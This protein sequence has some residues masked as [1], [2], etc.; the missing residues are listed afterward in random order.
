MV[1]K[2]HTLHTLLMKTHFIVLKLPGDKELKFGNGNMRPENFWEKAR[3][4][5]NAGK[6]EIISIR[7]DTG[8]SEE[9]RAHLAGLSGFTTYIIFNA[10]LTEEQVRDKA[11]LMTLAKQV[12]DKAESE[13]MVDFDEHFQLVSINQ[14]GEEKAA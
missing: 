4:D 9:L 5:V 13:V 6:S 10:S 2:L 12:I 8:I 7:H 3:I 11:V 14:V 1:Q